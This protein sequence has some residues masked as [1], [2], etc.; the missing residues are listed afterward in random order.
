MRSVIYSPESKRD[1]ADIFAY[2]NEHSVTA[3]SHLAEQ[4]DQKTAI[5]SAH[6]GIGRDRSELLVGLRSFVVGN[7]VV[8]FRVTLS[9]IEIVRV[10]HGARDIESFFN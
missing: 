4:I 9:S 8:F 6:P 10:L 7:Y 2:L 5:L 3:S 1:L